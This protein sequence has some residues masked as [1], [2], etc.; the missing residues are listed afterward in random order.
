MHVHVRHIHVPAFPQIH[1][2]DH[3]KLVDLHYT[4]AKS[5]GNSPELRQTWLDSMTALHLKYGNYSEAAQ[6]CIHI[7]GLVAEYLKIKSKGCGL[8]VRDEGHG[9]CVRDVRDMVYV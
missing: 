6:C 8:C 1:K 7:A 2:S 5:Y 3:E 4:L 9:L